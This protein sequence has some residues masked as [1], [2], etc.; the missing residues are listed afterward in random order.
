MSSSGSR[1]SA[2]PGFQMSRVSYGGGVG[3]SMGGGF[4]AGVGGGAGYGFTS[5]SSYG[6]GGG[7]MIAPISAVQVNT[8]LLAPLNLEID[9]TIQ[10]VRTQE[11]EQIKSLN[12]RFASFIDKVGPQSPFSASYYL[13]MSRDVVGTS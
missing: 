7:Q 6:S 5:S 13:L 12:N 2:G 9:P 11:K 3:S 8:S 1:R 10:T 4:G